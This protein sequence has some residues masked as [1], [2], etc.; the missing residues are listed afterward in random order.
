M[1]NYINQLNYYSFTYGWSLFE[2]I[3]LI[4][5]IVLLLNHN[6]LSKYAII[7]ALFLLVCSGIVIIIGNEVSA[8][9][10]A[11]LSFLLLVVTSIIQFIEDR[12][13]GNV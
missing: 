2:Y 13:H 12:R 6:L 10:I 8:G 7:L 3:F 4:V 11:G 1:N 9:Q 5:V